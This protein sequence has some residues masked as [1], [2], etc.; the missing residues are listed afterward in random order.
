MMKNE[1]LP[2]KVVSN[3]FALFCKGAVLSAQDL[4]ESRN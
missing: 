2:R 4:N 3:I 1:Q